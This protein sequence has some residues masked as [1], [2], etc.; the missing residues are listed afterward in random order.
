MIISVCNRTESNVSAFLWF[1]HH[2]DSRDDILCIFMHAAQT[3]VPVWPAHLNALTARGHV[4]VSLSRR[5]TQARA[6]S[7]I[8]NIN[9]WVHLEK[10]PPIV[11]RTTDS[12][13]LRYTASL[14]LHL[15]IAQK[16]RGLTGNKIRVT[17][18]KGCRINNTVTERQIRWHN[19]TKGRQCRLSQLALAWS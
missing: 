14:V 17:L 11:Q 15:T 9:S 19:P 2:S 12:V 16:S 4:P 6:A 3:R 7:I 1:L 5:I 13:S 10:R 18:P 8:T